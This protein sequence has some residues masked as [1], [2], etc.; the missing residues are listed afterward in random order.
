VSI[1]YTL[2]RIP[3]DH[4]DP[5]N[6]VVLSESERDALDTVP[7][8][9][10]PDWL[11]MQREMMRYPALWEA[12][13]TTRVLDAEWQTPETT[14]VGHVNHIL[15]NTFREQRVVGGFPGKLDSPVTERHIEH[16]AVTVDGCDLPGMRIDTDPDVYA[17]GRPERPD[18]DFGHR[19]R[20]SPIYFR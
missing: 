5:A 8:R 17:V 10:L 16:A 13:M 20:P 9:P 18:T 4:D 14:L 12:V 19:A 3:D 1:S 6:L 2:W 7:A 11:M 15:M